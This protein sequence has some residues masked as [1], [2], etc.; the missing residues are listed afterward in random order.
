[1]GEV[2]LN[3][4]KDTV[5]KTDKLVQLRNP[6]YVPGESVGHWGREFMKY[7]EKD[8]GINSCESVAALFLELFVNIWF[9]YARHMLKK[10][11]TSEINNIVKYQSVQK[12]SWN[13]NLE[14]M[15]KVSFPE[16]KLKT[17]KLDLGCIKLSIF[18]S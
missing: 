16:F 9:A 2:C 5:L 4:C 13:A 10:F 11:C 12:K 15:T 14:N 18:Q 8:L 1:M 3:A 17:Q 7:L 6:L